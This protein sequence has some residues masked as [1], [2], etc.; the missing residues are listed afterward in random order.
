MMTFFFSHSSPVMMTIN[1]GVKGD[2]VIRSVVLF[3]LEL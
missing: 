3:S 1:E 2:E